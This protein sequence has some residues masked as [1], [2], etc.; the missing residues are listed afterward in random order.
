MIV[1]A[2]IQQR[3]GFFGGKHK[4]LLENDSFE[5]NSIWVDEGNDGKT[6]NEV[7]PGT[8]AH[9]SLFGPNS[10]FFRR[11]LWHGKRTFVLRKVSVTENCG[12]RASS[13]IMIGAALC[14]MRFTRWIGNILSVIL[15][16]MHTCVCVCVNYH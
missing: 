4:S 7:E 6:V 3:V 13:L 1:P 2:S 10:D 16:C 15:I 11:I 9:L 8:L 12:L 14:T 5:I